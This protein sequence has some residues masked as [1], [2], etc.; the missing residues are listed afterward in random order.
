MDIYEFLAEHEIEYQRHDHPAVY[1]VDDVQRLI[2]DLPGT[3]TKNLFICDVKGK[4][5]FLIITEARKR[6]DLKALAAALDTRKVK[7]ASPRRLKQYLG[8]TPG[9]VSLVAVVNDNSKKVEVIIDRALWNFESFRFHPL[10]NTS[11]L[12]LTKQN[13]NRLLDATGHRATMLEVPG[14]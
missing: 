9:S 6:L 7:F 4:R 12:V 8:I 13:V 10:V 3:K 1:T 11:T 14:E 2:P 5:H